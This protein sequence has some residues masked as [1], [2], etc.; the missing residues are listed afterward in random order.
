[1]NSHHKV[2]KAVIAAAG[3]GTRFLVW[4]KSMPKE[5]L[6]L[7]GKPIIQHVVE[8]LVDAGIEEIIIVGSSSKRSIEDHFDYPSADLLENLRAGG[9]KKAHYIDMINEIADI[10]KFIYLRQKG[11]YGNGTPI[12]TASHLLI[13]EP[14]MFMFADDLFFTPKGVPSQVRQMIQIHEETGG[15][16]LACK[17]ITTDREFNSYGVVAGVEIRKG[18]IR[19]TTIIEKPGRE[20]APSN[21]ASVS[22]FLFTPEVVEALV[23]ASEKF[24]G[25]KEFMLQ[26]VI[27]KLIDQGFEFYAKEIERGIY[28]DTGDQLEYFKT[29]VDYAIRNKEYG[30]A[31]KEFILQKAE[32]IKNS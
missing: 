29:T 5:M 28:Y 6:Y 23:R 31:V 4:T 3:Y 2:K 8:E 12:V 14:F 19:M 22:G 7:D 15:S 20:N 32:E 13:D 9:A 16:V 1:M 26:P 21:L 11:R 10:A 18:L 17:K 27:Q 25:G 24:E 30:D